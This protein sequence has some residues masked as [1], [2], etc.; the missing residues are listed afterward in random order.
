MLHARLLSWIC[1]VSGR[2]LDT[3]F[4]SRCCPMLNMALPIY[5][6]AALLHVA[7]AAND[8]GHFGDWI[9]PDAYGG[10]A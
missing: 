10:A 6:F 2:I 1:E 9:Y 3:E 7:A 8:G 4:F 5:A